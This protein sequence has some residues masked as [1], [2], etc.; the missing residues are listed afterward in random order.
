MGI[1]EK[2]AKTPVLGDDV[3]RAGECIKK[4]RR[5]GSGNKDFLTVQDVIIAVLYRAKSYVRFIGA[6]I[7][8][9]ERL[10]P[11]SIST[12]YGG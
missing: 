10:V 4:V 2:E 3:L 11:D 8:F 7:R 1:N 9:G 6:G 12:G 5:T